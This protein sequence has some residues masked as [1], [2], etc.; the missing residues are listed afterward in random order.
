MHKKRASDLIMGGW[1]PPC[2][3]WDLNSEP[4][5]GQSVLLTTEPSCWPNNIFL[6]HQEVLPLKEYMGLHHSPQVLPVA[7]HVTWSKLQPSGPGDSWHC[8]TCLHLS[9]LLSPPVSLCS[10][11]QKYSPVFKTLVSWCQRDSSAIKSTG[12]SSRRPWSNP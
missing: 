10:W 8:P 4:S 6:T 3:C 7:L 9:Y 12:C 2:G 11:V 1:E 5:E